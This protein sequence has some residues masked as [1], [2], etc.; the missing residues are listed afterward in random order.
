MNEEIP[1]FPELKPKLSLVK[2]EA[3]RVGIG[4]INCDEMILKDH[5]GDR[6]QHDGGYTLCEK[7][8][9]DFMDSLYKGG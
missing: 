1:I 7:H 3:N 5:Y 4:V 2:C 8:S 9:K 6:P